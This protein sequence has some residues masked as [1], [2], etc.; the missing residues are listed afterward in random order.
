MPPTNPILLSSASAAP[1]A[2]LFLAENFYNSILKN[3]ENQAQKQQ[4]QEELLDIEGVATPFVKWVGGKRSIV[5]LLTARMP[6][7]FN[8]YWEPFTGGGALFF[9][10]QEDLAQSYLSD[11]NFDLIITYK[12]IQRDPTPLLEALKI[13]AQNHG[14][15][16]YYSVRKQHALQDPIAIAARFVYLNRTCYNGLWRVNSKGEFNVPFG[17]YTNPKIV[18]TNNLWACH[19][20][21]QKVDIRFGGFQE[22]TPQAG[23]FVYFDP[24]YHPTDETSFTKYSKSDFTE[25]DQVSLKNFAATLS[26]NHVH[27]MISNSDTQFIRSIYLEAGFKIATIQAPR[28]VNC[29]A[30]KRHAVNEVVIT[31]Y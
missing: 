25:T 21:L 30:E 29:K 22:I 12:I 26:A 24:P 28:F 5:E 2:E 17:R 15:E 27:V 3:F 23:D 1:Q 19:H 9:E 11:T 7:K 14:E 4:N 13:H 18:Q 8:Q 10:L 31:N 16:Y 20:A 6:I